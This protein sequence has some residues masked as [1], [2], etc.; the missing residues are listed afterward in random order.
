MAKQ[1]VNLGT[2][3]DN[4]SGDPLRTAFEKINENFDELYA[5]VNVNTVYQPD[6]NQGNYI[7]DVTKNIIVLVDIPGAWQLPDGTEGAK[8]SFVP[9]S[10]SNKRNIWIMGNIANWIYDENT[11]ALTTASV[12]T[13]WWINPFIT[14]GDN[15]TTSSTQAKTMVDAVF[16]NGAWHFQ[17]GVFD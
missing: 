9:A 6:P 3:A 1:T 13:G 15:D 4:K 14:Y 7:L 17:G 5:Q 10:S 8:I 2:M 16:V 12:G 11:Q